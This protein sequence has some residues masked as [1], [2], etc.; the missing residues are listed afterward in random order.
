MDKWEKLI[1]A[2]P[3]VLIGILLLIVW[4]FGGC[5]KENNQS[6]AKPPEEKKIICTE[7]YRPVCG[8]DGKTYGNECKARVANVAIKS[9]GDCDEEKGNPQCK[10]VD[11]S[12]YKVVITKYGM[13]RPEKGLRHKAYDPSN[14]KIKPCDKVAWINKDF[15][16][17]AI[18][19]TATA[20][21]SAKKFF[22]TRPLTK[23]KKSK[24]I[25]F[26]ELGKYPY[27]CKPHPHMKGEVTVAP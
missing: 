27:Y 24:A 2:K 14:L 10:G 13:T 17:S 3:L 1:I 7:E 12:T 26:V 9:R 19:H 5:S 21:K 15:R 22:E 8:V 11:F 4:L 18:Y 16:S 6:E 20:S 25:Q 23:G